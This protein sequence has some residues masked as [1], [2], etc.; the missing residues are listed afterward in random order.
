MQWLLRAVLAVAMLTPQLPFDGPIAVLTGVLIVLAFGGL[1]G[2]FNG[3]LV[4]WV[5]PSSW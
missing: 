1:A 3:A 2:A 4:A 5:F